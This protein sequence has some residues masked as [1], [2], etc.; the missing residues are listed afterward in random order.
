MAGKSKKARPKPS[1]K[2]PSRRG[3][4]IGTGLVVTGAAVV[5]GDE[6]S[7]LWWKM[8]G[9]DKQRTDGVVDQ[10]GA[11]W[12]A[13]SAGN[14]RT[15]D[16]PADY[17]IDRI[18]IHTT[19]G[20]YDT[21]IRVFRDP[22]HA[23]AAHYV[24]RAR[25][26]KITQMAREL[27]VAYHAGNRGFN[28]RSIGIE[29]EAF[30]HRKGTLTEVMYRSSARLA[31]GICAR[32]GIPVDREHIVGHVE[33]P[34]TDHTDP[35]PYWDWDHYLKLVREEAKRPRPTPVRST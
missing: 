16:R 24:V 7:R 13:A 10:P 20:S 31:A 23:A 18:V 30:A 2:K 6:A 1:A 17:S 32:Y 19:E 34:G 28:E 35:G 29:H 11:Q 25:D 8:P 22:L 9:V 15:A 5:W 12:V 3:F 14:L 33:I 27:D 21:A 4:L 26:G